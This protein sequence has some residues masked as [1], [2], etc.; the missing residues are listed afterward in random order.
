MAIVY[1]CQK[2]KGIYPDFSLFEYELFKTG[3]MFPYENNPLLN[4]VT[5]TAVFFGLF[6]SQANRLIISSVANN[7][8]ARAR[9]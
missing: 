1:L 9:E 6:F 4:G 5:Q 7:I 2:T 3:R 8:L